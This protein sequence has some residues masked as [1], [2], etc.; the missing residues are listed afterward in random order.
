MYEIL[1]LEGELELVEVRHQSQ[2]GEKKKKK[3]RQ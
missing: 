2:R 3:K 1:L